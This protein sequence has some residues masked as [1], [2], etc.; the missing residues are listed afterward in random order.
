M[1][2][3]IIQMMAFSK[4]MAIWTP[5]IT[6]WDH[7]NPSDQNNA[8]SGFGMLVSYQPVPLIVKLQISN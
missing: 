7:L 6:L 1:P 3:K 4:I 2:A 8:T 5:A